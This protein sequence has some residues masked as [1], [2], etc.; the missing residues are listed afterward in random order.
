VSSFGGIVEETKHQRLDDRA[1][2]LT[3]NQEVKEDTAQGGENRLSTPTTS[4][5]KPLDDARRRLGEQG[6]AG[7]RDSTTFQASGNHYL[8]EIA[9]ES[10]KVVEALTRK[11]EQPKAP[12]PL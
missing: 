10:G 1:R 2:R 5:K 3:K 8:D 6:D 12:A 4:K 9:C 7:L 11:F